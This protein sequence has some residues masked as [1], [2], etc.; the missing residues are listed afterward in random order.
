MSKQTPIKRG[1]RP[2]R[3]EAFQRILLLVEIAHSL[4]YN[5]LTATPVKSRRLAT[6]ATDSGW[7]EKVS[8]EVKKNKDFIIINI[9][10]VF[11]T[12]LRD[13]KQELYRVLN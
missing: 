5:L 4:C 6:L 2:E 11:N 3:W 9:V 10:I 1:S 8:D 7:Y 13:R 12:V